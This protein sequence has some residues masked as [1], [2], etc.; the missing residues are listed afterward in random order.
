MLNI[1][2]VRFVTGRFLLGGSG[3][4]SLPPQ[5]LL[6]RSTCFSKPVLSTPA[7]AI[8]LQGLVKSS[9]KQFLGAKRSEI[10]HITAFLVSPAL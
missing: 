4:V 5:L 8:S 10:L 2:F 7:K 9:L 6:H 3:S 1:Y